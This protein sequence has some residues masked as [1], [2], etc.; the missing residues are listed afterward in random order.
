METQENWGVTE[1]GFYCPTFEEILNDLIKRAKETFGDDIST[2]GQTA[3]GKFLRI[4]AAKD[5]KI[6]ETAENVY[7]SFSPATAR[8]VSLD[9]AVAFA[10]MKRNTST[11]YVHRIKVYGTRNYTVNIG[12]QFKDRRGISFYAVS[13]A[14]IENEETG[15]DESVSYYADVTV[16]CTRPGDIGNTRSID[17]PVTYDSNIT[18]VSFIETVSE[19]S[20]TEKD[21]SLR[22]RFNIVAE[23][24]GT[25]TGA[26]IISAV[27]RVNGVYSCTLQNNETE[28]PIV[29][30]SNFTIAPDTYAVIVYAGGGL[31]Q[32]IAEAI[33]SA[34]PFG[35][36]QSGNE[37]VSVL[38]D[39]GKYHT[40]KFTYVSEK[41]VSI[42]VR[43][44]VSSEF[45]STG[46]EQLETNIR[47][48]IDSLGIG[49]RLVYSKLYQYIYEITG[50]DEVMELTVN[51]GVLNI[52]A[53]DIEII[54]CGNVSIDITE[55]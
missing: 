21:P 24:L 42:S 3:L 12:Q 34:M 15:Q 49:K 22:N 13:E 7:Y 53:T 16:Q 32:K 46:R 29:V 43:C 9:R 33:F 30:S 54:R 52:S 6:Y 8:G 5:R 19:G 11:C 20:E 17:S 45:A 27:M 23:G 48:Y 18:G 31:S 50:V 28:L 40:V 37:S 2:N 1:Q 47:D 25:S 36:R 55:V 44:N 39:A 38:D 14:V 10:R 35:I 4:I 26:A 51:G 41:T